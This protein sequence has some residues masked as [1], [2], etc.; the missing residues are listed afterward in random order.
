MKTY[1]GYYDFFSKT[2]WE[3]IKKFE[4]KNGVKWWDKNS[5][6]DDVND[7]PL[8]EN[9]TNVKSSEYVILHDMLV[10]L[11]LDYIT[12]HPINNDVY[13]L[14]MEID[15]LKGSWRTYLNDL[16]DLDLSVPN[17]EKCDIKTLSPVMDEAIVKS[18]E[19]LYEHMYYFISEFIRRNR[20][21]YNE[22][23]TSVLFSTVNLKESLDE[24]KWMPSLDS[25]LSFYIDDDLIVC[26]M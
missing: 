26:S 12:E 13:A 20:D 15:L 7:L 21:K 18:Y 11:L 9:R 14:S 6:N 3:D 25:S 22:K 5:I 1:N 10:Q 24:D 19:D 23:I 4:K 8:I 17:G 16:E 2:C